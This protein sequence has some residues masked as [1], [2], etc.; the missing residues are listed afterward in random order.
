M[1]FLD[2]FRLSFAIAPTR[3]TTI[4]DD[5]MKLGKS[6]PSFFIRSNS[7]LNQWK[8]YSCG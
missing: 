5:F 6:G 4:H 8:E 2:C 7:V 3:L 1:P